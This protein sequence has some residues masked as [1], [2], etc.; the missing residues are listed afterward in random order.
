MTE[1]GGLGDLDAD[2]NVFVVSTQSNLNTEEGK[3][4]KKINIHIFQLFLH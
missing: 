1:S 3:I 2:G 4:H